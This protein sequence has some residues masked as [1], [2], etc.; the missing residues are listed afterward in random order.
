M[1]HRI[2][3]ARGE[4]LHLHDKGH[5]WRKYEVEKNAKMQTDLIEM[6]KYDNLV[7]ILVG[8]ERKQ[9][10]F[11]FFYDSVKVIYDSALQE[12]LV[13]M[14]KPT[15]NKYIQELVIPEIVAFKAI[16]RIREIQMRKY[17]E[18]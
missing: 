2:D 17:N 5:L 16:M 11:E 13:N 6:C 7:Q 10:Q 1:K 3:T 18:E 8:D 14:N 9:D 15:G 4:I 12:D